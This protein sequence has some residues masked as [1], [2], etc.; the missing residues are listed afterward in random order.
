M[1]CLGE[2]IV[3]FCRANDCQPHIACR[4]AQISTVQALI[5][6]GQGISLIPEMARHADPTTGNVYRTLADGKPTRTLGAVWHRHRYQSPVAHE[7]LG[8]LKGIE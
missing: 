3:S 1:H 8:C 2:Q 6:L 7:F 5:A 4:S